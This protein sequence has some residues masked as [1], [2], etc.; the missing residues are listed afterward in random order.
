MTRDLLIRSLKRIQKRLCAYKGPRCDC[1]FMDDETVHICSGSEN[2]SGCPEL[3]LASDLISAM[4]HI[5]F[6]RIV[7]RA[8]LSW[9]FDDIPSRK[10]KGNS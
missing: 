2:G 10:S 6:N 9:H 4:T 3:Y 8:K 1:K 7:K 5:E